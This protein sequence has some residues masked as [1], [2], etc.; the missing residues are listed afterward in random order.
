MNQY[1]LI[2]SKFRDAFQNHLS[3]PFERRYS[4]LH[5]TILPRVGCKSRG[6]CPDIA[7]LAAQGL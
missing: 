1:I 6:R 2:F 7:F 3:R 5:D 4:F